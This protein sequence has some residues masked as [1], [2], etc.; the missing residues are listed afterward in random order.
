MRDINEIIEELKSHP[1]YLTSDIWLWSAFISE[2]N[3]TID[4]G[5]PVKFEDLSKEDKES[6]K[7]S[8]DYVYQYGY[9]SCDIIP[10]DILTKYTEKARE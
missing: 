8:T 1:D 6:I 4:E 9:N 7:E 10:E 5:E 3:D 2:L